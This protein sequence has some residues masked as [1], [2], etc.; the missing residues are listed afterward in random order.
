MA[1]LAMYQQYLM[2]VA[3][4]KSV[5]DLYAYREQV[6]ESTVLQQDEKDSLTDLIKFRIEKLEER[7]HFYC[8]SC[9]HEFNPMEVPSCC[10][11]DCDIRVKKVTTKWGTWKQ[12]IKFYSL[13]KAMP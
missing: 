1:E 10:T 3:M 7:Y 12:F 5:R 9:D 13:A 2:L 6:G 11:D 4:A 8:E